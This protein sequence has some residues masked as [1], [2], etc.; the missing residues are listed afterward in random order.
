MDKDMCSKTRNRN[1][2]FQSLFLV[3]ALMS[4]ITFSA[5]EE[6]VRLVSA[7]RIESAKDNGI[8][9]RRLIGNVRMV[10][11]EAFMDC[12]EAFW[13][14]SRDQM[15]L[16]H[17]VKIFDGKRTL[18]AD[19]V[20]YDGRSRMEQATGHAKVESGAKTVTADRIMYWQEAE[21]V[22][23]WGHVA[24]RDT[25]ERL[26]L[27][28]DEA[29]YDRKRD[30]CLAEGNPRAVKFDTSAA[31]KDWRICGRKMETWGVEK[32]ALI[33]DSVSIEQEDMKAV[34]RL[35]DYLSGKDLLILR[36]S[37]KVFQP[38]RE[39]LGDSMAIKL[40]GNRFQ[41]GRV[42]GKAQIISSD[43]T[44]QDELKGERITIEARGDTLDRVVVEEQAESFFRVLDKDNIKQGVNTVTGDQIELVFDGDK[45]K[46]VEV[47]SRPGLC[48]GEYKPTK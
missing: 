25:I 29:S 9:V 48:T 18:W 23:A 19:E 7:D 14:E 39:I 20:L 47:M 17:N 22:N 43:S 3:F 33:T 26:L 36:C 38:N 30:Y 11:G 44:G 21:Q 35:A 40:K 15:R 1:R 41:G 13:Y 8:L 2:N 28:S 46:Q 32:R 24:V 16:L 31:K 42:F 27:E 45:L 6:R 34:S 5:S 37:P 4:T 10:Q 12:T